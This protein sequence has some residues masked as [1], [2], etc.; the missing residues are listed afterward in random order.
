MNGYVWQRFFGDVYF[1][2]IFA[3]KDDNDD[4]RHEGV[5]ILSNAG[6]RQDLCSVTLTTSSNNE[7]K[8]VIYKIYF[9]VF[10]LKQR[11]VVPYFLG[12]V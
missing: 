5:D 11:S 1:I 2:Y 10:S 4:G 6:A 12:L 3:I 7:F 9:S 8:S